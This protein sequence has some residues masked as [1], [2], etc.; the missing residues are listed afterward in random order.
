MPT[1]RPQAKVHSRQ[2][3]LLMAIW[4]TPHGLVLTSE[5]QGRMSPG[6]VG[7]NLEALRRRG[8]LQRQGEMWSLTDSGRQLAAGIEKR[9]PL[10]AGPAMAT[11]AQAAYIESLCDI[12]GGCVPSQPLRRAEASAFIEGLLAR[13]KR[14]DRLRTPPR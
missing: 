3:A 10:G 2:I 5:M 6:K 1:G 7:A 13:K 4:R 8:Y 12:V 11:E 14:G 9:S